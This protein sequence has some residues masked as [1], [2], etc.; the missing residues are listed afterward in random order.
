MKFELTLMLLATVTI[1]LAVVLLPDGRLHVVFCDVGQGDA[2]LISYKN[3][4]I[5]VDAGPGKEVVRCLSRYIPFY[6]KKIEA[7]ILTHQNYDHSEGMAEVLKRYKVD[8]WE[9][10]LRSGQLITLGPVRFAVV[11]PETQIL[12]SDTISSEN[13]L[14]IVGKIQYGS[15]NVLMT[16]DVSTKNYPAEPGIEIF[17]VPHHGS[18]TG[19]TGDWLERARPKMAVI[20]VGKNSFGHPAEEIIKLISDQGIKLLRTDQEGDIEIISDGKSFR[21]K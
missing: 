21:V 19:I 12:G 3:W 11:W 13:D 7:V 16:G 14:G 8:I 5:L 17:K 6:D 20:S 18:K 10:K 4:Q 15:F 9:P 1:W 2:T